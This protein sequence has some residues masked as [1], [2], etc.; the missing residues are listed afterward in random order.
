MNKF[1]KVFIFLFITGIGSKAQMV[2]PKATD[3]TKALF[4]NLRKLM[5]QGLMMGHQDAMAYGINADKSSWTNQDAK[6]DIK[7]VCGDYPA[8]YGWELGCLELDSSCNL[9]HVN[10][11]R[12][13]FWIKEAYKRGGLITISWHANNPTNGENAWNTKGNAVHK[14]LPGG[15]LAEKYKTWLNK[16]AA[17]LKD[18]NDDAGKPIPIIFRPYHEN[19]GNWFWWGNMSDKA[20]YKA[21]WHYTISYFRDTL[22]IH[23]LLYAYSPINVYT[24]AEYLDRYPG[25][26]CI[27]VIGLD[28]YG[29]ND[30]RFI[31]TLQIIAQI[32]V[33]RNKIPALTETGVNKQERATFWTEELLGQIKKDKLAKKVIYALAWRNADQTQFF[34]PY[35]G[36]PIVSDFL[37]FYNDPFSIFNRDMPD[38]YHINP[39]IQYKKTVK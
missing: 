2:D 28:N 30:K 34:A 20:E 12:M 35:P 5:G 16:V 10:F 21:L 6:S 32:A 25:D 14:V 29:S 7:E 26:E 11:G 8:V 31:K 39:N 37:K 1:I 33:D 19:T 17:F 22:N 38:L 15:E 27:D 3:E 36:H 4:F 23:N 18:L 13:K 24:K 9:D